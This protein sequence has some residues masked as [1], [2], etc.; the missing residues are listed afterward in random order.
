MICS[1]GVRTLRKPASIAAALAERS[2]PSTLLEQVGAIAFEPLKG[3][4]R[5]VAA[6]VLQFDIVNLK[7]L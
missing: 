3:V 6:H 5:R 2:P 7:P 4:E 1:R